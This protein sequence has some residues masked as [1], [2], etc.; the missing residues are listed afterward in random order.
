M[1]IVHYKGHDYFNYMK[2]YDPMTLTYLSAEE[3]QE[4]HIW[5][6]KINIISI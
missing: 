5:G 2:Y 4:N 1:N 6:I 3:V